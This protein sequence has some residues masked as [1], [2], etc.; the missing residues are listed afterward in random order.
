MKYIYLSLLSLWSLTTY[1][2]IGINSDDSTPD[3]SAMLHVKSHNKGMLIPRMTHA[4]I[5]AI[6]NPANGLQ[7]FNT[8][9]NKM[10]IYC[11][12]LNKWQ[13]V[14]YGSNEII[15]SDYTIGTG[16]LCNNTTVNGLYYQGFE[17]NTSNYVSLEVNVNTTGNWSIITDM[18]NGY[19]FSGS[20]F[21]TTTGTVQVTLYGTGTPVTAQTDTFTVTANNLAGTCTFDVTVKSCGTPI[22]DTRDGQSYNTVQIGTQCWM[23]ENLNIGNQIYYGYGSGFQSDNGIIEKYCYNNDV[24]NCN[25]YGGLYQWNETMQY[26]TT[27]STQGICPSGWHIPSDDEWKTLEMHLGM[28]QTDADATGWRLDGLVGGKLKETGT[29]HWASP[30]NV[31]PP[32]SGFLA[33]PGGGFDPLGS[34][35]NLTINAH[36]WTSTYASTA[37]AID[38]EL[39]NNT[40]RVGRFTNLV[41]TLAKS[42]RC[43][44]DYGHSDHADFSIGSGG[45]CA[46]TNVNGSYKKGVALDETNTITLVANVN[47]PGYWVV[48]TNTINGYTF[49][50]SGV[51]STTGMQQ[52]ILTG[53]GTPVSGQTDTFTATANNSGGT[54]TFDVSV[55]E[56]GLPITDSRDGKSYNTVQIGTQCWMAENL[57]IGTAIMNGTNNQT[58]NGIIEKYCYNNDIN[59]CNTYGGLYQWNEAM[60]YV[61]TPSPQGICPSGWHIP[62]DDEWKTLEMHLGM[63]QSDADATGWR[64][65]GL[66][67]GQLKERGTTHWASPN[68]IWNPDSGFLALPGGARIYGGSW[69]VDIT[70]HAY[71]W[72]STYSSST[73]AIDRELGNTTLRV[74]RFTTVGQ[75]MGRSIRCVRD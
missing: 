3:N 27:P 55:W 28:P 36:F 14:Q 65:G 1:A 40:L 4:Q 59:N 49:N 64:L 34:F 60:Q 70:T 43:V 8:D 46:A 26:I 75:D 38:R 68:N 21:F 9:D 42:V 17:L 61:T 45:L 24:N 63:P 69:F 58:N 33:L 41:K 37:Y 22:T 62:S 25:T 5:M 18:V 35:S 29:T 52:I 16:N 71:F 12:S 30:N 31:W 53:T 72:T 48:T 56:C 57:N 15:V 7:V 6:P 67:G 23:A 13:E 44:K 51:F 32:D 54:C 50:G 73:Y 2:Q 11:S 20:G 19:R 66:V 74:G 47:T 10:Y 39:G